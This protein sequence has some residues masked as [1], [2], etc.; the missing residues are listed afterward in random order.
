MDVKNKSN[1]TNYGKQNF[2]TYE[3]VLRPGVKYTDNS[4]IYFEVS[5]IYINISLPPCV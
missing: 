3:D 5:D 1:S 2:I 4:L